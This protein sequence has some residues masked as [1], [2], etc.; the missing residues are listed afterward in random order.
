VSETELRPTAERDAALDQKMQ[1]IE[2]KASLT[3][4][5]VGRA[6]GVGRIVGG[7][8]SRHGVVLNARGPPSSSAS[9]VIVE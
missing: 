3:I 6:A 8:G 1:A 9:R 7:A 2:V 5:F 4:D